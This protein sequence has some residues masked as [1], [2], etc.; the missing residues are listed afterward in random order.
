MEPLSG[1]TGADTSAPNP[2]WS[3]FG[4]A[5]VDGR[6]LLPEIAAALELGRRFIETVMGFNGRII[7]RAF[8]IA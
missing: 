7:S 3:A 2:G 5:Q 4:G 8:F 1:G 6:A